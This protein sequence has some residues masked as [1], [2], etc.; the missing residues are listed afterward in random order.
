M[1]NA[2]RRLCLALAASILLHASILTPWRLMFTDNSEAGFQPVV[3]ATIRPPAPEQKKPP[4]PPQK[5]AAK[6]APVKPDEQRPGEKR[7]A[8]EKS[9]AALQTAAD[10][11]E[12]PVAEPPPADEDAIARDA[13]QIDQ[14]LPPEYPLQARE[15]GIEGCVLAAVAVAAD[16][17][18]T[19]VDILVA[20]PP[21]I[22]DQA[23]IE[24]QL[25]TRYAAAR[26]GGSPVDSRVLTV[27]SFVI[28]PGTRL[29]CALK[30]APQARRYLGEPRKPENGQNIVN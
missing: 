9:S 17:T 1:S 12:P 26:R 6:P 3:V 2:T 5:K 15:R 19:K 30:M 27:A 25:T 21:G 13:Y 11:R 18:V 10:T 8:L 23:V 14:P 28:K 4:E 20:E 29:N 24:S 7:L 22:F 16:G